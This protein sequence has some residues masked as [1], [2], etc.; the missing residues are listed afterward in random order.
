MS[1][2]HGFQGDPMEHDEQELRQRFTSA[3]GRL[4]PDVTALVQE[5]ESRGER[6]RRRQRL[7]AGAGIVAAAVLT[8]GAVA[9]GP[10]LVDHDSAGPTDTGPT[11]SAQ[12]VDA[13]P[14]GMAAAVLSHLDES[15]VFAVAGQSEP[16]QGHR[17]LVADIGVRADG[18]KIEL[19]VVASDD[20]S[21]W[22]DNPGCDATAQTGDRQVVWC[23][24]A[25]GPGGVPAF[26]QLTKIQATSD[27]TYYMA[28]TGVLRDDGQ[29]VAAI[30]TFRAL[31]GQDVT[32]DSMPIGF[33]VLEQIVA[34]PAVGLSTTA[35]L[36]HQGDAI[37][38]FKD[39]LM[40]SSG[41]ATASAVPAESSGVPVKTVPTYSSSTSAATATANSDH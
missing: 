14:R 41:S 23:S 13:T 5:G 38:D 27:A 6:L 10:S 25:D 30:A 29:L 17:E 18:D 12:L 28:V 11:G 19:Q 15:A 8:I 9:V 34:D 4:S 3:V 33:D 7:Q 16:D 20:V 22:N 36:N 1:I 2:D 24:E 37:K 26:R 40:T 32:I 39:S 31:S 35:E 21:M